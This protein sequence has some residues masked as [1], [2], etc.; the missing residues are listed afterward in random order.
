M[1][2]SKY[3][4]F[5]KHYDTIRDVLRNFYL[6][7]CYSR[8]DFDQKK[9]SRRK[10]DNE[11]R[12]IMNYMNGKYV[13]QHTEGHTKYISLN[14]DMFTCTENFLSYSFLTRSFNWNDIVLYFLIQQMLSEKEQSMTIEELM[15]ACIAKL[16][17]EAENFQSF[18]IS[19]L[20]RKVKQMSSE[21]LL[22]LEIDKNKK[23]YRISNDFFSC[24][25]N[26]EIVLLLE[27]VTFFSNTAA[28]CVPGVYLSDTIKNYLKY[29]RGIDIDPCDSIMY[30]HT[31]LQ[32]ILDDEIT[33]III[34]CISSN[35]KIRFKYGAN[36][37]Q[38]HVIPLKMIQD[39]QYGRQ[40]LYGLDM[41]S[42][43]F[44]LFRIDRIHNARQDHQEKP[45]DNK[46]QTYEKATYK[47]WCATLFDKSQGLTAVEVEIHL[48]ENIYGYIL[49]RFRR[50]GK[51]GTLTKLKKNRY[52]YRIEVTDPN[53]MIPW[54]RT[55]AGFI[56]IRESNSHNISEKL[57]TDWK[58]ALKK[59]GLV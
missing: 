5:I 12:R 43:Q 7:G 29:E 46:Y 25:T 6:Y 42:N 24:L 32:S 11:K 31:H 47:S 40:Y 9:I 59:Y 30:K 52:L 2:K 20:R 1:G 49:D 21:N 10:Y 17:N 41:I 18:E 37:V 13:K 57:D 38:K 33:W 28:I 19:T 4:N 26:E 14:Y 23:R 3:K 15:D 55:F 36:D 45:R 34:N 22:E 8:N 16:S 58:E 48:D 51:W 56:K 39:I 27:A 50:E 54:L 35:Q 44:S 53:E